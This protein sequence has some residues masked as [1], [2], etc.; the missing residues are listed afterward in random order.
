MTGIPYSTGVLADGVGRRRRRAA[1]GRAA[2]QHR[3]THV[4]TARTGGAG[5]YARESLRY[6]RVPAGASLGAGADRARI[7]ARKRRIPARRHQRPRR[8][9]RGARRTRH[10]HCRQ[11]RVG[12]VRAGARRRA[13]CAHRGG[14]QLPASLPRKHGAFPSRGASRAGRHRGRAA[15]R[16]AD[17]LAGVSWSP[18]PADSVGS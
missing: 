16:A 9:H 4:R 15:G 2:P 3:P 5:N 7:A 6:R 17:L 14:S 10:D 8:Q 13:H 11:R 1:A 12:A 18:P